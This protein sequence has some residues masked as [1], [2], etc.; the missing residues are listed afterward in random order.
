[1]HKIAYYLVN[2]ATDWQVVD[3]R[4]FAVYAAQGPG[5][6]RGSR[7]GHI[8]GAINL[9]FTELLDSEGC[10]K[11]NK[12]LIKIAS[13][14]NIDTTQPIVTS[15]QTGVTACIADLALAILGSEK[16]SLYDGSWAEYVSTSIL[17]T[18]RRFFVSPEQH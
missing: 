3:T 7:L 4:P 11:P 10:L 9:P 6:T 16:T 8:R 18:S 5:P 13:R 17:V 12:D 1:M 14:H 2:K 15:C